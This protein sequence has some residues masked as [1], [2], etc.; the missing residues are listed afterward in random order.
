MTQYRDNLGTFI[1]PDKLMER[2]MN[3]VPPVEEDLSPADLFDEFAD[4]DMWKLVKVIKSTSSNATHRV[5]RRGN[6]LR[7]TCQGFRIGKKGYCKHTQQV[8]KELG[9]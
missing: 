5:E 6:E 2:V 3:Y 8:A 9:I 7:C 1:I 4:S